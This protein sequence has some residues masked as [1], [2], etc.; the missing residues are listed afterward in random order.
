[1]SMYNY[2]CIHVHNVQAWTP[3]SNHRVDKHASLRWRYSVAS[4]IFM[5]LMVSSFSLN[6]YK[7]QKCSEWQTNL[8]S[9][10]FRVIL[11]SMANLQRNISA[12]ACIEGPHALIFWRQFFP[13]LATSNRILRI[14]GRVQLKGQGGSKA[15]CCYDFLF[16]R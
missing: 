8:C 15:I 11:S 5:R 13:G 16:S 14:N 7:L 6:R 4:L 2:T 1:M 10:L 3:A 12:S 9:E